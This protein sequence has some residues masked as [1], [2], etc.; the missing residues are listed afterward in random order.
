MA[1]IH[2]PLPDIKLITAG[3]YRERDILQQLQQGLPDSFDACH[4]VQ[5]SSLH[6]HNR[7]FGEIDL[8]VLSPQGNLVLLEV[9]AGD[10][11]IDEHGITKQYSSDPIVAF[12]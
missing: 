3:A 2:P 4:S 11:S 1:T 8:V 7:R 6:D 12:A 5:W 10:V 9:K